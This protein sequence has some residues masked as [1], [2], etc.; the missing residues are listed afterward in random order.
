MDEH[1]APGPDGGAPPAGR[2]RPVRRA[3]R[4]DA[5]ENR[6][7][8]LAAARQAFQTSGPGVSMEVIA[9]EAGIGPATLYRHFVSKDA[10]VSELVSAFY[11]K[12]LRLAAEAGR[13]EPDVALG[14]FLRTVGWQIATSRGILPRS[15]GELARPEQVSRLQELTAELLAGAQRSGSVNNQLTLTD[16]AMAVWAL[17]GVIETSGS[18]DPDVWQRHL[19]VV[20][21]GFRADR[22]DLR[23][24]PL[25]APDIAR[26]AA[27]EV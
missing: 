10:L 26:A 19:A 12:L 24:P 1:G 13:H 2:K 16:V 17:R 8:I 23:R 7:R 5:A 11:D 15:W 21:A 20:M 18:V 14:E 6:E 4:R 9:R 3:Q 25:E 27:G 22:L